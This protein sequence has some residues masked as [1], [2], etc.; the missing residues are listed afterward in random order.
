MQM[1]KLL[2]QLEQKQQAPKLVVLHLVQVSACRQNNFMHEL[3]S[4]VYANKAEETI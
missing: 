2:R 3:R 4:K 1:E